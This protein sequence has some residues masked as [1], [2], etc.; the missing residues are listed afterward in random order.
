MMREFEDQNSA[1]TLQV[2]EWVRR[3]SSTYIAIRHFLKIDFER[4]AP[5]QDSNDP[6][7]LED[8]CCLPPLKMA[9]DPVVIS[10]SVDRSSRTVHNESHNAFSRGVAPPGAMVMQ[11][12]DASQRNILN[13]SIDCT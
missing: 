1:A 13:G 10:E 5:A 9:A 3:A 4:Q 2:R 7:Q 6:T 11:W 8:Q 12:K